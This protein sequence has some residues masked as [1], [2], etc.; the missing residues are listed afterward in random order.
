MEGRS[1]NLKPDL[2]EDSHFDGS[3]AN[4]IALVHH[5][6][7]NIGLPNRTPYWIISGE[8]TLGNAI[9]TTHP[10]LRSVTLLLCNHLN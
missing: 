10:E 1:T 6:T 8:E 3:K 2:K 7:T 9:S 5:A 4:F